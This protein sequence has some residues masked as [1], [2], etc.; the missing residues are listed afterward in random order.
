MKA[1]VLFPALLIIA[2]FVM[3]GITV[4]DTPKVPEPAIEKAATSTL[5]L[6]PNEQ[7]I[8]AGEQGE[9]IRYGKEL[10]QEP[11]HGEIIMLQ[12]TVPIQNSGNVRLAWKLY[13]SA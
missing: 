12:F 2:L 6:P 10:I 5:W 8:P 11:N 13:Q 9:L 3:V 7:S 4:M 1:S